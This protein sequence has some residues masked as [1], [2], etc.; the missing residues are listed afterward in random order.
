LLPYLVTEI[1]QL[2]F[3]LLL[4]RLDRYEAERA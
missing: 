4:A 1:G 3:I 2:Q